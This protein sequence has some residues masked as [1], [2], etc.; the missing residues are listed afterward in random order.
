VFDEEIVAT[1]NSI[2]QEGVV[3]SEDEKTY[4]E[5]QC[6]KLEVYLR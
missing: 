1:Q 4:S 6:A 2:I 5:Q 3:A